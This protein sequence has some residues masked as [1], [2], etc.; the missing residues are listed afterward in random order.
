MWGARTLSPGSPGPGGLGGRRG[1]RAGTSRGSPRPRLCSSGTYRKSMAAAEVGEGA[2]APSQG[3]RV[4]SLLQHPACPKLS[5][6]GQPCQAWQSHADEPSP[7]CPLSPSIP[8]Q[9]PLLGCHQLRLSTQGAVRACLPRAAPC[10]G[11]LPEPSSRVPIL[12]ASRPQP[13]AF[14][15]QPRRASLGLPGQEQ[16]EA[17]V[18]LPSFCFPCTC[19]APMFP[20]AFPLP[21]QTVLPLLPALGLPVPTLPS[22]QPPGTGRSRHPSPCSIF[23]RHVPFGDRKLLHL[24]S[25]SSGACHGEAGGCCPPIPG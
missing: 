19:L 20:V 2:A 8:L 6:P 17:R 3:P 22:R 14:R 16:P 9:L 11:H 12:G 13:R 7:A 23:T 25:S 5:C 15:R 10:A 4:A 1:W 21:S 24:H 18:S